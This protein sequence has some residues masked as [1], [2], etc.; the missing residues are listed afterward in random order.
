M[1]RRKTTAWAAALFVLALTARLGAGWVM[2]VGDRWE[3]GDEPWYYDIIVSLARGG[4][5]AMVGQQSIDQVPRPTARYMPVPIAIMAL[6]KVAFG[7]GQL[8]CRV[9]AMVFSSLSAPLMFLFARRFARPAPALLAGAVC[10]VYPSWVFHSVG[11]LTE[12]F[13]V[14]ILLLALLLTARELDAPTPRNPILAGLSWGLAIMTR[15]HALPMLALITPYAIYRKNY[16]LALCLVAGAAA[17]LLPWFVRN[18]TSVGHPIVLSTEGGETFLGANNPYVL[19]EGRHYGMWVIPLTI[20]EY[21]D[22]LRPIQ[23]E[24]LRDREQYAI[25]MRF[26]AERPGVIPHLVVSKL[27][28]WLTPVTESGG[29]TR[30]VVLGTYGLMLVLLAVGTARGVHRRGSTAL[31]LV[32]LCTAAQMVVTAVYWGNLLRGR[33]PLELLWIPWAVLAVFPAGATG[34]PEPEPSG[35]SPEA[36]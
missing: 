31:H 22:R 4:G 13:F 25:G 27:A 11:I 19:A 12:P 28:R 9:V 10:A 5:Y 8:T 36:T 1:E 20:P 24:Y 6:G 7:G 21:R 29:K 3:T 32:L 26:L 14:P 17:F 34:P 23:D 18:V 33:L 35:E 16:R 15:V 30:L 2:G